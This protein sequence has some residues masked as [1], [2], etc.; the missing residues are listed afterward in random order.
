MKGMTTWQI[1]ETCGVAQRTV[2]DWVRKAS[3][4]SAVVSA[5]SAEGRGKGARYSLEETLAIVRAGGRH[6]LAALLQENAR[7]GRGETRIGRFPNGAQLTELRRIFGPAE[8][9]RRVDYAIGYSR[10]EAVASP[11]FA[12]RQFD[13]IK[14]NL[15]QR[16]L[17]FK[18]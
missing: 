6:T 12:R 13:R 8:A 1:A 11:D 14:D 18:G 2:R 5:K 9:A 17:D 3:A 4:E 7:N 15:K 16:K 10:A